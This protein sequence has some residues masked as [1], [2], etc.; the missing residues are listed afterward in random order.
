MLSLSKY[1]Y[2]LSLPF[3][4]SKIF[5]HII[6]EISLR[7][8]NLVLNRIMLSLSIP[9]FLCNNIRDLSLSLSLQLF[10]TYFLQNNNNRTF[11]SINRILFLSLSLPR[12][13]SLLLQYLF[14]KFFNLDFALTELQLPQQYIQ[15]CFLCLHKIN[16]HSYVRNPNFPTTFADK[17]KEYNQIK[18]SGTPQ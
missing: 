4:F 1:S 6:L 3:S 14:V 11:S 17:Q 2:Y 5:T 18:V 7:P 12:S 9:F 10:C 16:Q 8:T 13:P 15:K